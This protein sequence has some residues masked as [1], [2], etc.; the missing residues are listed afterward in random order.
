MAKRPVFSIV[1]I[2]GAGSRTP[3]TSDH[4]STLGIPAAMGRTFTADDPDPGAPTVIVLSN[5]GWRRYFDA[6]PDAR[7][8]ES[9][10]NLSRRWTRTRYILNLNH[11][12]RTKL[13]DACGFHASMR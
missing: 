4:L 13:M 9:H 10:Q 12:W 8:R 5:V 11:V 1:T 6:R 7:C 3:I 2:A